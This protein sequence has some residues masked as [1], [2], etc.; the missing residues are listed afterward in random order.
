MTVGTKWPYGMAWEIN[1]V[2]GHRLIWHTGGGFGFYA[3]ISR[4]VD[5]R[6]TIIVLTN[7][8]EAHSDVLKIAGALAS[9]YLPDTRGANPVRD[10]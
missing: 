10:W 3:S 6:L 4:F 1:D 2:H 9:L 7:L 8:G 5:D